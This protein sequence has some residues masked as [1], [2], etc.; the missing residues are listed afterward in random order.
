MKFL[1]RYLAMNLLAWALV[2]FQVQ[3]ARAHLMVAQH[4]TLNVIDDGV[5]MVLSLPISAFEGIDGDR[6]G[7]VTMVEFNNYR[8]AIVDSIRGNVILGGAEE[9]ATLQ[10]LVLSPVQPHDINSGVISQLAVMGRFSLRDPV[11]ALRFHLGLF[12]TQ[13]VERSMEITV[14]RKRDKRKAVFE[15]TPGAPSSLIFPDGS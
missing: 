4:G 13:T 10:D 11:A 3:P 14:T 8:G 6:D 9:N 2:F 1:P 5:F 15:L 12:G 7:K